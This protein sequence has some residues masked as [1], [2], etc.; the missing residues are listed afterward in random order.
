MYLESEDVP[1]AAI[2]VRNLAENKSSKCGLDSVAGHVLLVTQYK[3][4][5]KLCIIAL[6]K[7]STCYCVISLVHVGTTGT[8]KLRMLRQVVMQ[9][10]PQ[11]G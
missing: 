10:Q 1:E 11:T 9:E 8:L 7:L 2:H 4:N 3:Y 6:S 5:R